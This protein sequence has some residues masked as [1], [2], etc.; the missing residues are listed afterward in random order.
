MKEKNEK[1]A[2]AAQS[3]TR[4][5]KSFLV[6][7]MSTTASYMCTEFNFNQ[8]LCCKRVV[9]FENYLNGVEAL[10]DDEM[11]R[12]MY[13]QPVF[14]LQEALVDEQ[15]AYKE[16]A[17]GRYRWNGFIL[18]RC[19]DKAKGRENILKHANDLN[20]AL[21]Y[22]SPI[23]NRYYFLVK[24]DAETFDDNTLSKY[25]YKYK[26]LLR[27]HGIEAYWMPMAYFVRAFAE[28]HYDIIDRDLLFGKE[29]IIDEPSAAP[30]GKEKKSLPKGV[31][32]VG[33]ILTTV[34]SL[35]LRRR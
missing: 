9:R 21:A 23:D 26:D 35:L 30:V 28:N 20:V 11:C 6:K 17:V 34:L 19:D 10:S 24:T 16:D 22:D 15:S 4:T 13:N 5:G 8:S 2:I 14:Y 29:T 31:K 18:Y 25:Q 12:L 1:S 3:T 32:I 27:N 33:E 7:P